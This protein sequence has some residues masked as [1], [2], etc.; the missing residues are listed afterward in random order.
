MLR[1]FVSLRSLL[2][3]TTFACLLLSFTRIADEVSFSGPLH[4]PTTG[5][6]EEPLFAIW[7]VTQHQ[8]VYVDPFKIPYAESIYN[9]L[10][11]ASYGAVGTFFTTGLGLD[12]QWLP[13]ITRLLTLLLAATCSFAFWY[14][15]KEAR[16]WPRHWRS[17]EKVCL[18]TIAIWNPL[19]GLFVFSARPDMAALF[20]EL[21]GLALFLRYVRT[22]TRSLL[23]LSTFV[24]FCAWSF[25][26]T[27]VFVLAGVLLWLALSKRFNDGAVVGLVSGALYA[28]VF[29][30]G[31]AF[32]SYAMLSSQNTC[33]FRVSHAVSNLIRA[34]QRSSFLLLAIV[35]WPIACFSRRSEWR[36]QARSLLGVVLL[37]CFLCYTAISM[38]RGAGANYFITPSVLAMLWL[39]GSWDAIANPRSSPILNGIIAAAFSLEFLEAGLLFAAHL[40]VNHAPAE[41]QRH[42]NLAHKLDSLEA[43]ILVDERFDNL[44]WI[45]RKPPHFVYS[46]A[47]SDNRL[48]GK[49]FESGGLGGLIRNH[50]FKTVVLHNEP[51]IQT[52]FDEGNLDDYERIETSD[53]YDIYVLAKPRDSLGQDK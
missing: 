29:L 15:A 23:V 30:V 7:K 45:Q 41:Q 12:C 36:N 14:L 46:F 6:E 47:Y 43:P 9:W 44:P 21:L 38:K 26:Q 1:R 27:S 16:F 49:G 20:F 25:K 17:L 34:L 5:L 28:V 2:V 39:I 10:F 18:A 42:R 3:L 52:S 51:R 22:G 40:R 35:A 37:V 4:R 32:Y 50:Y 19:T 13:T 33:E 31:G 11:Y 24:L 53:G 8:P 48:A